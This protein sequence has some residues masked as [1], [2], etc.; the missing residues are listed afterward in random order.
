MCCKD[1]EVRVKKMSY[2]DIEVVCSEY[3][4]MSKKRKFGKK[5]SKYSSVVAQCVYFL[6]FGRKGKERFKSAKISSLAYV[7]R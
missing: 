3:H 2:M 5:V 6:H 1:V 7:N 4:F